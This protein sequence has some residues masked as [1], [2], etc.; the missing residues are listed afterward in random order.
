[1]RATTQRKLVWS[2][3][4]LNLALIL[5]FWWSG[6]SYMLS[7]G[8]PGSILLAAGRLTGLLAEFFILV[9]L[10]L[11]SRAPFIEKVY[12]FDK[13]NNLHRTIGY[14][15]GA[16]ILS[17]PLLV[18]LAYA[19]M[20]G[21]SYW[22]Q[23][24]QITTMPYVG[25]AALGLM[26][27]LFLVVLALPFIR[28]RI[29]YGRWHAMHMLMYLAIGLV[30]GHQIKEGVVSYGAGLYYWLILNLIVFGAVLVY[31]FIKPFILYARHKFYIDK[32]VQETP[33]IF[34]VYIKGQNMDKFSFEA[35]QYINVSF[36]AKKMWE[37]HP[38]SLSV[39]PNGEY[40]RLSIKSSGDFT[41][42][43]RDLIPGTK[44]MIE[45]PL[46][47]FTESSSARNKYLFIAG[48]IGITPI[49]SIIESLS[50]KN[51]DMI[52]LYAC[53]SVEDI[54]LKGELDALINKPH[55]VLSLTPDSSFESG[56]I[57]KEKI[58]KLVPDYM[59]REVFLC[60]PLPMMEAMT[61]HTLKDLG[62]PKSQIHYEMFNY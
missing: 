10:I 60:G 62:I 52:L 33:D 21:L 54:A 53:R 27:M 46:G 9:Q 3:F 51:G 58:L 1:M 42:V 39:A 6:S 31:R 22:E 24:L 48:G 8:G 47:R 15:L 37:P 41:S 20:S 13:L 23:Y 36:L 18:T 44:V 49:R 40:L 45:G 61:L 32:V 35:G 7:Q 16:T 29:R 56:Y 30:F 12:G 25:F 2:L 38:F 5:Y 19:K 26:I 50:R 59:D 4:F 57:D 55:Y 17:H 14:I 11:I 43:I 28:S 34:S